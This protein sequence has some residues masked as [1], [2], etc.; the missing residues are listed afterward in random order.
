MSRRFSLVVTLSVGV[1]VALLLSGAAGTLDN[2][3][4]DPWRSAPV[5]LPSGQTSTL[6]PDGRWLFL[7][8]EGP[9]GPLAT[10]TLWDPHTA[11]LTTVAHS[12]QFP[13][14]WHSATVLPDGTVLIL[15]GLGADGQA[16]AAAEVFAPDTQI[17]TSLLTPSVTPRVFHSTTLLTDGRVLIVGGVATTGE[18]LNTAEL[19]DP[20]TRT[21]EVMLGTLHTARWHH[22]ATLLP[23]G[24]VLVH[25]GQDDAGTVLD[26][27]EV[28]DPDSQDFT[29]SDVPSSIPHSALPNPQLIASLPEDGA[30]HVPLDSLIAL[31]FSQPLQVETVNTGTVT[32]TGPRGAEAITVTPAEGG[33]LAF[34]LPDMP[35][36]PGTTYT[37]SLD[38][39]TDETGFALPVTILSFTT[40]SVLSTT[41]Q[42]AQSGQT[43]KQPTP[44]DKDDDED[45]IL[46]AKNFKGAWRSGRLNSPM[47]ELPPLQAEP[48]ITALAGQVLT[49]NGKPLAGVT[50][51]IE[52][53]YGAGQ[54]TARTDETGR[55]LLTDIM[56]GWCEL[57]I[58]GRTAS[59]GGKTY[60]VFEVGV[61]VIAGQT[62]VLSY[63]IWMP[64]IDT[65]HAVTISSPTTT[66]VVITT[67]YIP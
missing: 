56:S 49:L 60:G 67:P 35:L 15:G 43:Q 14:A 17:F 53:M 64:Q 6:L 37:L 61:E 51:Q 41:R 58:D 54:V 65:K 13:R 52:G 23:D 48:G 5:P 2:G 32:L 66:E 46:G 1:A 11:T 55:F 36:H 7:G 8:G 39:P 44:D 47:R 29:A 42:S 16:V 24:T 45:W 31:R 50:L 3:R 21:G 40:V 22:R 10:A 33:M 57:L 26:D 59:K 62:N 63:T 25:G 38:G 9:S 4:Q 28:Y 30:S 34:I 20:Q 18:R 12:L 27:S 19:W